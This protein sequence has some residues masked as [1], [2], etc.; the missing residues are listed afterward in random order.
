MNKP[1]IDDN[2]SRDERERLQSSLAADETLLWAGKPTPQQQR[3]A[4]LFLMLVG[5]GY[6]VAAGTFVY[7]FAQFVHSWFSG[8][9]MSLGLLLSLFIFTLLLAKGLYMLSRLW[10]R[11]W[12]KAHIV[13]AVTDRR[14]LVIYRHPFRGYQTKAWPPQYLS[15][16]ENGDG[17]GDIIFR[18]AKHRTGIHLTPDRFPDVAQ[19]RQVQSLIDQINPLHVEP[20]STTNSG[21]ISGAELPQVPQAASSRA[22][23]VKA[24]GISVLCLIIALVSG[25]ICCTQAL[26]SWNI[27]RTYLPTQGTVTHLEK[28]RSHGRRGMRTRVKAHYR[29]TVD[30]RSYRGQESISSNLSTR[31]VGD[32]IRI[33]YNPENPEEN[34]SASFIDLWFSTILPLIIFAVSLTVAILGL[35]HN[36]PGNKTPHD[37]G[38]SP[39]AHGTKATP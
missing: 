3:R 28:H 21:T 33:L 19:V 31:S 4:D 17:S 20:T 14:C 25:W 27:Q 23:R 18:T 39:K 35:R 24:A 34:C 36:L 6:L 38:A 5:L 16:T 9:T 8:D 37:P 1:W 22:H 11:R 15:V 32:T 13:A 12:Q 29:F 26:E 2:L 30:H 7:I 10:I